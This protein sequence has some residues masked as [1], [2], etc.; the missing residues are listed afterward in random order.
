MSVSRE[1]QVERSEQ[2]VA[3]DVRGR[4]AAH[5]RVVLTLSD[6]CMVQRVEG[7]IEYVAVTG[8]YCIV[9]GWHIP[10]IDVVGVAAPHFHQ[11]PDMR[12]VK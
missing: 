11:R 10:M 5:K 2:D 9:D 7:V 12:L 8:A 3:W 4:W 1:T 6:R